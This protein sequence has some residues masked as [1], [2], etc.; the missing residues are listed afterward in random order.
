MN[1]LTLLTDCIDEIK[2]MIRRKTLYAPFDGMLGICLINEGQ[3]LQSGAPIVPLNLLDVLSVSF[4]L[5]QHD[6]SDLYVG[7]PI[8]VRADGVPH[9]IFYGTITQ[10]NSELD[11]V[12]RNIKV[13]GGIKN[14]EMLLRGG[15]FVTVEVILPTRKKVI[16]VPDTA[17]NYTPY[18]DSVF[19]IETTNN[20]NQSSVQHVREQPVTLGAT[21]GDQVEI[22]TGLKVGDEIA[23]SGIFKLHSGCAVKVNNSV[24]PENESSPNPIDS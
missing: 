2:I 1:K 4:A 22:L 21:R 15:M 11:P 9:K 6:F 13:S 7:Q 19:I 12:T 5:P 24:Q 8:R 3:Y 20:G 23:T 17:I 18:G 14:K 16:T 10:L